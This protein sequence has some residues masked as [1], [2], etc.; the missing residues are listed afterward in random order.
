M[1]KKKKEIDS[2][3]IG[4]PSFGSQF[5]DLDKKQDVFDTAHV[6]TVNVA[7]A[8]TVNVAH[9]STANA[10]NVAHVST[11]HAAHAAAT[12]PTLTAPRATHR[13]PTTLIQDS[14][15]SS[16][17]SH[18][19]LAKD[20]A[21]TLVY[22]SVDV[23]TD[24]PVPGLFSMLSIGLCAFTIS[25]EIVWEKELN[26]L[27]LKDAQ[28]DE[29]TMKWWMQPEQADSWNHLMKNRRNPQDAMIQLSQDLTNLKKHYK[30]VTVAWPA[31]FDWMFLHWYMYKFIGDNPLGRSAKCGVSYAW[32]R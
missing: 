24:G 21:Q 4:H 22:L 18:R 5:I 31:C 13:R 30:V 12:A 19:P 10:A 7:H 3:F 2:A 28:Q 29:Q 32:S 8:S 11:V 16:H 9:V 20:K 23:E 17:H 1:S 15:H 27:P 14:S 26:L 25:G 6:S